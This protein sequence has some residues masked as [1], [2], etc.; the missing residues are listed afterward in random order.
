[1]E[2]EAVTVISV[3][4][5]HA[6]DFVKA[7]ADY[8]NINDALVRPSEYNAQRDKH[9]EHGVDATTPMTGGPGGSLAVELS[10][11]TKQVGYIHA[12]T[13]RWTG[14]RQPVIN[15]EVAPRRKLLLSAVGGNGETGRKGGDG[16]PGLAG[17]AGAAATQMADAENGTDGGNGGNAGRGTNGGNGG[18]GGSIQILLGH[19]MTHLLY[20]VSWDVS[21]GSGTP[22]GEHG[23][24]GKGGAAGVGGV[25]T[26]WEQFVGYR[27]RC[28]PNCLGK[29]TQ[30]IRAT[31]PSNALLM[32]STSLARSGT[33]V[34]AAIGSEN[35]AGS[36]L[37][38]AVA[39][40]AARYHA[41]PRQSPITRSL[42]RAPGEPGQDGKDG[43]ERTSILKP[44][45][46]GAF[47]KMVILVQNLD[48]TISEY[49]IPWK[50][51]LVS[52]DIED[53]NGDGIFEPGEKIV[54]RRVCVENIELPNI[55]N[56]CHEFP[57]A[58]AHI[59]PKAASISSQMLKI[60]REA[61]APS[62]FDLNL[63]LYIA[64][65]TFWQD[66][67]SDSEVEMI[68]A[69]MITVEVHVSKSYHFNENASIVMVVNS[70]THPDRVLALQRF[71]QGELNMTVDCLDVN[72]NDGLQVDEDIE[73]A[74]LFTKYDGRTV[75]LL[76]QPFLFQNSPRSIPELCDSRQIRRFLNSGTSFLFLGHHD[77][78]TSNKLFEQVVFEVAHEHSSTLASIPRS[79]RFACI[80]DF[81]GA[82]LDQKQHMEGSSPTVFA[83]SG[84]RR[85]CNGMLN[86][87]IISQAKA[88][89]RKLHK[90]L[91]QER[92][93]ILPVSEQSG[94]SSRVGDQIII[95]WGA[96]A[97]VPLQVT[98]IRDT[99]NAS[100][101]HFEKYS[102][103]AALP[104]ARR[105]QQIWD[106]ETDGSTSFVR[107]AALCSL[108]IECI[109]QID[110]YAFS[111]FSTG[112]VKVFTENVLAVHLPT[113]A[114]VFFHPRSS[115]IIPQAVQDVLFYC[116][117]T[118]Q[119]QTK[120][121]ALAR[122]LMWKNSN[123]RRLAKYLMESMGA[124]SQGLAAKI[125]RQ[126]DE[127]RGQKLDAM[128]QVVRRAARL[129]KTSEHAFERSTE[130]TVD[131]V[132]GSEVC[133]AE[134]WDAR[135]A[136]NQ[137]AWKR[138]AED[139]SRAP[140]PIDTMSRSNV[141]A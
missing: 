100:L 4:G 116:L 105:V 126:A 134:D 137:D 76:G 8:P 57:I 52:F 88:A 115:K 101:D 28:T 15:T 70:T 10:E 59:E 90:L 103:I 39:L 46:P 84:R 37:Q 30:E 18:D 9:G 81:V 7:Q 50:L 11:S 71:I 36:D 95:L 66:D 12:A 17:T 86:P 118:C 29:N 92:F 24:A 129:T 110:R 44:G 56:D 1:M 42:H 131:V 61:R 125:Q 16:H 77:D 40:I 21:G 58:M 121:Q 122:G 87:S 49:D 136:A 104:V 79:A 114:A 72:E 97:T 80:S 113:V 32:A 68:L 117:E 138:I 54:I 91:P 107:E 73:L 26:D 106:D 120:L 64:E 65:S 111:A 27:Y 45:L 2:E 141:V 38:T 5:Q 53:E 74:H 93:S 35:V 89:S 135:W 43:V 133:T 69:Q 123:R 23:R 124:L 99:F 127:H 119:S 98:E 20:A 96:G 139:E 19:D 34:R 128:R 130:S 48:G 13:L 108:G 75:L 78:R 60:K 31:S 51:R 140:Q 67:K 63:A 109:R 25:G 94:S 132:R 41:R 85:R 22:A 6:D 47:G 55:V 62:R 83:L 14:V 112:P 82:I 102:I 33:R 3:N